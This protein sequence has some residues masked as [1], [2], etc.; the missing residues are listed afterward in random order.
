[1]SQKV[2]YTIG[3]S[4]R[5]QE[6]FVALLKS[7]QINQLIDVRRFP[8]SRFDHFRRE[9]L[10]E[11][12]KKEGIGY[13]Y[14]GRELGGYRT[15][16]Y[17]SYTRTAAFSQAIA[18]LEELASEKRCVI[19]CAEKFPWRCHRRFIAQALERRGWQVIHILDRGRSWF[20]NCS[21]EQWS[22]ARN[23]SPGAKASCG[24]KDGK[25]AQGLLGLNV[26]FQSLPLARNFL[27]NLHTGA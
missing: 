22:K 18:V 17:E 15:G 21:T 19:M 26:Q 5:S 7:Y 25:G 4:T 2:I 16:G 1:M 11:S 27:D 9:A 20:R 10:S 6:E 14:L 24:E 12:L 13:S 3:S 8:T 23:S